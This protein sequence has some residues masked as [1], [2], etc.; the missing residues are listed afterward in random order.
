M[1]SI[2]SLFRRPPAA[3]VAADMLAEAERAVLEH[4]AAAE[5]HIAMRDMLTLRV[6]RLS[7]RGD[8]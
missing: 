4:A 1:K 6:D 2:L 3:T 7:Q 8:E 5:Y